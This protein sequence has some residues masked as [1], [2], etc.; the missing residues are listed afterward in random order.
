[1][2]GAT[3]VREGEKLEIFFPKRK[4]IK[5][6]K[7]R[8]NAKFAKKVKSRLRGASDPTSK[9]K[10]NATGI[11]KLVSP[12]SRDYTAKYKRATAMLFSEN[13]KN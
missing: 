12:G 1:M 13:G 7:E 2:H 5:L 9:V 10:K 3:K 8:Q 6:V 4:K 11:T